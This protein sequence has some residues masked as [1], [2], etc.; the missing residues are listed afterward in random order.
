MDDGESEDSGQRR[1]KDPSRTRFNTRMT[2][3]VPVLKGKRS[4][5]A[6]LAG[7][8]LLQD[9]PNARSAAL[10][11][12]ADAAGAAAGKG[13]LAGREQ[14]TA[15]VR[16][17]QAARRAVLPPTPGPPPAQAPPAPTLPLKPPS[18]LEI[19]F[20]H[21]PFS[22][23]VNSAALTSAALTSAVEL[24]TSGSQGAELCGRNVPRPPGSLATAPLDPEEHKPPMI[25]IPK[26][27]G[28]R[29]SVTGAAFYG[30]GQKGADGG[31]RFTGTG[32]GIRLAKA[33]DAVKTR[34]SFAV[35][36]LRRPSKLNDPPKSAAMVMRGTGPRRSAMDRRCG[37]VIC[38]TIFL[39]VV[40]CLVFLILKYGNLQPTFS[41]SFMS[42]P[43]SGPSATAAAP[44]AAAV[45]Y[46]QLDP[47]CACVQEQ[48][49]GS[50]CDRTFGT[51]MS[52]SLDKFRIP[53]AQFYDF[54]VAANST[55]GPFT[56]ETETS[57]AESPASF[58]V[59]VAG[60]AERQNSALA[61]LQASTAQFVVDSGG[62]APDATVFKNLTESIVSMA[63]QNPAARS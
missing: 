2:V 7:A 48:A 45:L 49:A 46:A 18:P 17:A 9:A 1:P 43:T 23:A 39:G 37:A 11:Q 57:I 4:A 58:L 25:Q 51:G 16:H 8:A 44:A 59:L 47:G 14:S 54:L 55:Q 52:A 33:L 28:P 35:S 10:G 12:P 24:T 26:P 22:A 30:L 38:F 61:G 34:V 60:W 21:M 56:C 36:G 19:D 15:A 20:D 6:R 3:S 50:R 42:R 27:K 62:V 13:G 40:A 32:R 5:A 63:L 29:S 53:R 41:R 31:Q